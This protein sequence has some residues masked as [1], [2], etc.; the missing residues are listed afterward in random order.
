MLGFG[1]AR[2]AQVYTKLAS[3][4]EAGIPL[5]TAIEK[6]DDPALVRA[7]QALGDGKLPG[8]AWEHG[9]FSP[10]EIVIVRAGAKGGQL[11]ESFRSLSEIFE[12]RARTKRD[13]ALGL[14][15]PVFLLHAVVLIPQLPLLV[16]N[17]LG[18][19]LRATLVPLGIAY[20]VVLVLASTAKPVKRAFPQL[21]DG[22]VGRLPL[23]GGLAR[24]NALAHGLHAFL[25]LYRAGVPAREA[26][27]M[28]SDAAPLSQVRWAFRRVG[29][30]LASGATI[31]DAFFQEKTFPVLVREA[32]STGSVSGHLEETLGAA[33]RQIAEEA[34]ALK[35]M[36]LG[37]LPVLAFFVAAAAVGWTVISWAKGYADMLNKLGG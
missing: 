16:S 4:E 26:V 27:D 23:V 1:E 7:A 36:L 8:E 10:L 32:A 35:R 34:K 21:V 25:A 18:A 14:A 12:D 5:K 28:A 29:E 9:G 31:G 2:R 6:I 15:Y 30:R 13:L 20:A 37:M 24:R 19:Y 11:V 22:I 3:L 17:G 33:S